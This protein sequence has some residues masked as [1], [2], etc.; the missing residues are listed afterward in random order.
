MHGSVDLWII[1]CADPTTGLG[2]VDHARIREAG[3][4]QGPCLC[5]QD[6]DPRTAP[7]KRISARQ[8]DQASTEDDNMRGA[9]GH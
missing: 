5:F 1:H 6:G 4:M 3:P 7:Y 8:A 9:G 2:G